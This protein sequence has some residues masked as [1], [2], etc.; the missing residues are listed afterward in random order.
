MLVF[1]KIKPDLVSASCLA[2]GMF[3]G[4]HLG[5]Q[6]VIMNAVKKAGNQNA[7][8]VILTFLNHPQN[9]TAKTPAK[10]ITTLEERLE[11]FE[12]LGVQVAVVLDFTEDFSKI[13]AIDYIKTVLVDSLNAKNISIG[14]DH[15]FGAQKKGDTKLLEMYGKQ[16]GYK[17][18]VIS[19]VIIDGQI[20]SSSDIRKFIATGDVLWASKLLGRPF[21]LRGTITKGKQRGRKLG[22]PTIN[23]P[24]PENIISPASGVYSGLVE[25]KGKSHF[26]VINI[27]K[28]PTFGDLEENIAEAHI[29]DFNGDLYNKNIEI[30]FLRKLRDEKKFSSEDELKNQIQIDCNMTVQSII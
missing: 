2:L 8:S 7:L 1:K 26:A 23:L 29:L 16:Y 15:R 30:A 22:F 27:G 11:L 6:K 20:A 21:S 14:Y 19:P 18:S 28:R 13:S 5:H 25:I 12:G 4:V 3:D 17:V 24:L 9:I 10:L